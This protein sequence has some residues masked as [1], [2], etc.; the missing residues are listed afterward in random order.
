M[1]ELLRKGEREREREREKKKRSKLGYEWK[2]IN[3]WGFRN[4]DRFEGKI[5]TYINKINTKINIYK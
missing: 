2:A 5:H 3:V 1:V 4:E